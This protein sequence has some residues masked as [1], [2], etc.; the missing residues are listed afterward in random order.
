MEPDKEL[1]NIRI[2]V[3]EKNMR[4]IERIIGEGEERFLKDYRTTLAGKHA[5]LESIEACIDIGNH[6]I[7]S[8]G[9][10]RPEDYRD[11]FEILEENG[12][13][14]K[15]LSERLQEMAGFRNLLVHYYAK[16]DNKKVFNIMKED[17]KDL[18]EFIKTILKYIGKKTEF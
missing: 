17:T 15:N 11:I 3:I 16:M 18:P 10:R 4:E 6:I 1:I 9:L 5:L 7:A 8:I 2:D 13:I 14:P 12:A